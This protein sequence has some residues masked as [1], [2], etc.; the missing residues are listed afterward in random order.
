MWN[1]DFF[2]NRG[3]IVKSST[4]AISL[5]VDRYDKELST[6]ALNNLGLNMR[7]GYKAIN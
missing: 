3:V 4:T 6:G 2:D 5:L 7:Y 1:R